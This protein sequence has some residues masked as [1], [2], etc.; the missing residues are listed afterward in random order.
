M[1]W[2]KK[3]LVKIFFHEKKISTKKIV[4]EKK[5]GE[6]F[7]EKYTGCPKK[8]VPKIV[9]RISLPTNKLDGCAISHLK[10]GIFSSV[11][12]TKHFCTISE[13]CNIRRSKLDIIQNILN[14]G[15]S[16]LFKSNVSYCFVYILVPLYCTDM[17]FTLKLTEG[18]MFDIS[19]P[20][21]KFI[22]RK[23]M[24]KSRPYQISRY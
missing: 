21:K 24:N 7:F 10:G 11:W 4:S 14:I 15:W 20:Y 5:I 8:N 9:C 2:Q 1:S 23:I 18:R 12:S 13:S 19:P 16:F 3:N 6:L 22:A 17:G